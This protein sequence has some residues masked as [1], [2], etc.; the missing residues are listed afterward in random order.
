MGQIADRLNRA[1]VAGFEGHRERVVVPISTLQ[2]ELALCQR[3]YWRTGGIDTYQYL[4][5]GIANSGLTAYIVLNPPVTM[6]VKPTS[7]DTSTLAF[8]N[9]GSIYPIT[10]F[11]GIGAGNG[12]VEISASVSSGLTAYTPYFLI[13]NNSTSGYIGL[14]AEL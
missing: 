2:G 3:Y 10:S 14:S 6:R 4:G 9:A 11:G 8:Y 12:P 5:Q 13:T 7:A 1:Y